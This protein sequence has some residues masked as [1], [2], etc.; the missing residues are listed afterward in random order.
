MQIVFTLED[1]VTLVL[2][3]LFILIL[4][5][6]GLFALYGKL[7]DKFNRKRRGKEK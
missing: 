3:G 4:I 6:I 7:V 2:L 5:F 1:M